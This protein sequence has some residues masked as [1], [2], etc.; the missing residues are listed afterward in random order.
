KTVNGVTVFSDASV[1]TP[2]LP[3]TALKLSGAGTYSQTVLFTNVDVYVAAAYFTDPSLTS[4]TDSPLQAVQKQKVVAL[5]LSMLM[6]LSAS[7]VANKFAD[8]FDQNGIDSSAADWNT[9]QD[10]L[11]QITDPFVAGEAATFLGYTNT[12]GSQT[13]YIQGGGKTIRGSFKGLADDF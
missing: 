5:Q 12:D 4:G 7:Q 8:G 13:Y 3:A 6:D 1:T 11:S 9:I 10:M 2:D